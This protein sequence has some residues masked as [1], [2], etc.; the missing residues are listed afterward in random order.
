MENILSMASV[1]SCL[2]YTM[3]EFPQLSLSSLRGQCHGF[4]W[5]VETLWIL[6]PFLMMVRHNDW[7]YFQIFFQKLIIIYITFCVY[8]F[9][10]VHQGILDK[11]ETRK[12]HWWRTINIHLHMLLSNCKKEAHLGSIFHLRKPGN[13]SNPEQPITPS[14]NRCIS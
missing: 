12:I 3:Y 8:I 14:G 1:T 5:V 2:I 13:V 10:A 4:L 7:L 11:T 9:Q 6:G